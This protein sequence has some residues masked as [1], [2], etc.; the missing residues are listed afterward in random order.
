[1]VMREIN[2]ISDLSLPNKSA[3]AVH[4]MKICDNFVKNGFKVN[5]NIYSKNKDLSFSK[6]KT[7][8]SIKKQ[9]KHSILF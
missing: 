6:I 3:Y 9:D 5:L 4:V 7:T 8:I 1:M 2:Y